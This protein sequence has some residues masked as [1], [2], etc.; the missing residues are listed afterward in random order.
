M[1]RIEWTTEEIDGIVH[2][3][4]EY[5]D[6][7]QGKDWRGKPGPYL[8]DIYEDERNGH[9][10]WNYII[11]IPENDL[12]PKWTRGICAIAGNS[13]DRLRDAKNYTIGKAIDY[14]VNY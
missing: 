6:T 12:S 14:W 8:M 3:K 1:S 4:A 7:Y 2:H 10:F 5:T 9:R 13:D 11:T